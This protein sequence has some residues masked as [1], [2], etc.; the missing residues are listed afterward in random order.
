MKLRGPLPKRVGATQQDCLAI[1]RNHGFA[2]R[3]GLVS[4]FHTLHRASAAHSAVCQKVLAADSFDLTNTPLYS[5]KMW[6][7]VWLVEHETPSTLTILEQIH[8]RRDSGTI[9]TAVMTGD[10]RYPRVYKARHC[11]CGTR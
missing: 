5:P 11:A 2:G 8:T 4:L 3:L 7:S 9:M 10:D 6:T 1:C